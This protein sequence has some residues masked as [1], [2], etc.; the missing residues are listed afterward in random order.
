LVVSRSQLAGPANA[1]AKVSVLC[2]STMTP[3]QDLLG[4]RRAT[5]LHTGRSVSCGLCFLWSARAA[6]LERCTRKGDAGDPAGQRHAALGASRLVALGARRRRRRRGTAA[7]PPAQYGVQEQRRP[8]QDREAGRLHEQPCHAQV[9]DGPQPQR[10]C[11][12]RSWPLVDLWRLR[13]C[14]Q[15]R[16]SPAG[17][18][19]V[20][21]SPLHVGRRELQA[22][23]AI[24]QWH[25]DTP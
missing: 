7:K 15:A 3:S 9:P 16:C 17:A 18:L 22:T 1:L 8:E 12:R 11:A 13:S 20:A 24:E 23:Q 19:P 21:V 25:S 2:L 5:G 6:F 10:R 14:L 4:S